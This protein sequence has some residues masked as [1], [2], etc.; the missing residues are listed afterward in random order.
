MQRFNEI[1]IEGAF[2]YISRLYNEQTSS[3]HELYENSIPGL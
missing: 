2:L 1:H 3:F